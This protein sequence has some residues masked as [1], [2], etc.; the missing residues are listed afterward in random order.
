MVTWYR[1]SQNCEN[2]YGESI[3]INKLLRLDT[4]EVIE[5]QYMTIMI[6]DENRNKHGIHTIHT[7]NSLDGIITVDGIKWT[8]S[9]RN[10]WEN[11]LRNRKLEKEK[12]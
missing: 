3:T 9:M 4:N 6:D 1:P 2:A 7:I 5:E 11:F 10:Q 12:A 8:F